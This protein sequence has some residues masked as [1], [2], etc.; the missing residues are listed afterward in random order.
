MRRP[1]LVVLFLVIPPTVAAV[2]AA[3]L[4]LPRRFAVV[5]A[6]GVYRGGFPSASQLRNLVADHGIRTVVNLTDDRPDDLRERE[7]QA[8]CAEE[9]VQVRRFPMPGD[10]RA[11][12]GVLRAAGDAVADRGAW[13]VFFHCAAGKMR[14]NAVTAAYRMQH[15]GWTVDSALEEL[16][17][18][19]GLDPRDPKDRALEDHLRKYAA[20]LGAQPAPAH[21]P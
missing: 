19:H 1:I 12:F 6:D 11:D 4:R 14:S 3:R 18:S 13:P 9:G 10:G 17:Q 2:G 8:V 20:W 7:E 15:C 21:G 16:R 5:E